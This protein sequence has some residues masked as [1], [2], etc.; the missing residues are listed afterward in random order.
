MTRLIDPSL[1]KLSQIMSEMGDMAV[2]CISLGIDSYLEG[3]NTMDR[4]QKLSD[5]IRKTCSC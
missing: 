2:E 5:S 1:E 4:V 3:T